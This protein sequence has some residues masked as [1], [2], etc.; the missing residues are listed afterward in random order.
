MPEIMLRLL[1]SAEPA[2]IDHIKKIN[3]AFHLIDFRF[4]L[5]RDL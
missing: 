2:N 5:G 1:R 3:A 4:N